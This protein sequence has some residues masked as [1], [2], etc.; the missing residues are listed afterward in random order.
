MIDSAL[1]NRFINVRH[2]IVRK[3]IVLFRSVA[4]RKD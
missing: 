3:R 1:P 2:Y 4:G